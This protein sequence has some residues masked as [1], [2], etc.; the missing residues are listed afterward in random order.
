MKSGFRTKA[1]SIASALVLAAIVSQPA[2]AE[3]SGY[4]SVK[5]GANWLDD[6]SSS[7]DR[8]EFDAGF[9]FFGAIGLDTGEIWEA[10]KVRLEAEIGYR[11]ND[12]DNVRIGG[13]NFSSS[14]DV[15]QLSFMANVYHDFLPGSQIRPYLGVGLGIVDGDVSGNVGGFSVSNSGTEFAYQAMAGLSYQVDSQWAIDAEYR[16]TGVDSSP[17]LENHAILV[18]LRFGF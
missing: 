6:V 18:G 16:F 3:Q 14:G 13:V 11:E 7:G 17:D 4:V 12:I 15:E 2:S 10:G 1:A 9:A 5:G 8:A